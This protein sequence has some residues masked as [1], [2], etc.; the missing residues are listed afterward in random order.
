MASDRIRIEQQPTAADHA[1][2]RAGGRGRARHRA[3]ANH[4][5]LRKRAFAHRLALPF[6]ETTTT[7]GL[8]FRVI[9][10]GTD[11]ARAMISDSRSL[12][13]ATVQVVSSLGADSIA[14]LRNRC[15]YP[16][17]KGVAVRGTTG[18]GRGLFRAPTPW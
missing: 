1:V 11:R 4:Q 3:A 18:H 6:L 14:G 13:P 5:G 8:P 2:R 16:D 7:R 17:C 15:D 12:A 9:A 10:W